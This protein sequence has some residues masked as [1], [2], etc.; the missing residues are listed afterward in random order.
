MMSSSDI[1]VLGGSYGIFGMCGM[2]LRPKEASRFSPGG[3]HCPKRVNV[4]LK[5]HDVTFICLIMVLIMTFNVKQY[6]YVFLALL[7]FCDLKLN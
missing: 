5:G 2:F 7:A 3:Q 4:T 6:Y 1:G